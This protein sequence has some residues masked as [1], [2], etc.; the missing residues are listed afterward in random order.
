MSLCLCLS[1]CLS[2]LSLSLCH[3]MSLSISLYLSCL[4]VC[5]PLFH[6]LSCCKAPRRS[7]LLSLVLSHLGK[8]TTGVSGTSG[9]VR[10]QGLGP[11][12]LDFSFI[13][14]GP[15]AKPAALPGFSPIPRLPEPLPQVASAA[16]T[17]GAW[18]GE[19]PACPRA[20]ALRRAFVGLLILL[21]CPLLVDRLERGHGC[22]GS[23]V[24]ESLGFTVPEISHRQT[25][26]KNT[27]EGETGRDGEGDTHTALSRCV[28]A[29][30]RDPTCV[31]L[32]ECS[33]VHVCM[34]VLMRD[35]PRVL[36]TCVPACARAH[37]C[38]H[39]CACARTQ[40]CAHPCSVLTCVYAHVSVHGCVSP[41]SGA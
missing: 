8:L 22:S 16:L 32:H 5:L 37:V 13:L 7:W 21:G 34:Y 30:V 18:D 25:R 27:W 40:I 36:P 2:F 19:L 23:D 35:A 3:C 9:R 1:L 6:G 4:C 28:S 11:L 14:Q 24:R 38:A 20:S 10:S 39:A 31:Y 41:L 17:A 29:C 26:R 15:S 12:V 33:Y